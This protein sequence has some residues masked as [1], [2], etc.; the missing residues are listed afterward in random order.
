MIKDK[1]N[2][3]LIIKLHSGT[4]A[5]GTVTGGVESFVDF[6]ETF[7]FCAEADLFTTFSVTFVAAVSLLFVIFPLKYFLF[8][9]F[10][11][12]R[13]NQI[14]LYIFFLHDLQVVINLLYT[15]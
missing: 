7:N 10:V 1:N 8:F 14:N 6:K 3:L 9:P 15:S 2:S 12:L 11:K 4:V 5:G 13:S